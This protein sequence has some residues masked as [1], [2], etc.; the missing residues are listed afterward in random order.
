[1]DGPSIASMDSDVAAQD[2]GEKQAGS[3]EIR[4]KHMN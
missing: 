2:R 3:F 1:V 4:H